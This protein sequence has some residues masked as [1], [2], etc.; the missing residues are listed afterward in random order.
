[1]RALEPDRQAPVL[2]F[3][4]PDSRHQ[5][6]P[7]AL[8]LGAFDYVDSWPELF[9]AVERVFEPAPGDPSPQAH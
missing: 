6:R 8:K 2:V 5:N 3:S 9:A 7:Q 1:M 4:R